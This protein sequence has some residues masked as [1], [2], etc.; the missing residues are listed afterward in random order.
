M[1]LRAGRMDPRSEL[2]AD[3]VSGRLACD[4]YQS[5]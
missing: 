3:R 5:S 2:A 1:P 4:Q